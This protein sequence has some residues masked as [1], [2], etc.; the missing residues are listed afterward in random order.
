MVSCSKVKLNLV[1]VHI[2]TDTEAFTGNFQCLN[3]SRFHFYCS[4]IKQYR[5]LKENTHAVTHAPTITP[6]RKRHTMKSAQFLVTF[7][8]QS[9]ITE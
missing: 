1:E 8:N 6:T 5:Q 4:F 3:V 9:P 2:F 7:K